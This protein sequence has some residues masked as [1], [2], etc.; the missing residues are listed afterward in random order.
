MTESIYANLPEENTKNHSDD[1]SAISVTE[2]CE[3]IRL[4]SA[5]G[6]LPDLPVNYAHR[7]TLLSNNVNT[8]PGRNT[9]KQVCQYCKQVC[10]NRAGLISHQR[11][12]KL[13]KVKQQEM[14]LLHVQ[15]Q[16]VVN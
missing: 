10:K 15:V 12:S 1:M 8:T 5:F 2:L 3:S 14:N 11:M 7:P 4:I 6:S 9:T 16:T 13:C